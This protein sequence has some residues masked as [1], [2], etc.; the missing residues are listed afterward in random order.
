[1]KARRFLAVVLAVGLL[2]L[3]LGLGGWWWVLQRSPLRLQQQA[4][5]VP[6]TAR[7]MPR[8]V[9]LS[10]FLCS[11]GEQPVAY[12]RAVAPT[13]LRRQ[14]SDAVAALRDGAFAAAG[15]DYRT[16]LASWLGPEIGLGLIATDPG[17]PP[18]GW[19][20]ALRSR[21]ADGARRFLQRFWQTRSLAGA[22][23]QISSYRGM[24]LISGRGALPGADTAP[25]ATALIDEDLVLIASGRGVL[26]QA[27]DVSQLDELNL[28]ASPVVRQAV[29]RLGRGAALLTA[30]A[31]GLSGGLGL[32]D[33][34]DGE[35]RTLVA[36]LRPDGTSLELEGFLERSADV[37]PWR[38]R[39]DPQRGADLLS[40]LA[41]DAASLA[42]IENPAGWPELLQP[43]LS[44]VLAPSAGPLPPLLLAADAGPLLW[45]QSAAGW[46]VGTAAE[47]PPLELLDQALARQSLI[48]APLQLADQAAVRVWTSL[49]AA[50]RGSRRTSQ[51]PELQ[52]E[53]AGVRA[54]DGGLAWWAEN[55]AVLAEQ[56]TG[57]QPPRRRL[58]Q[59][60]E[61]GLPSAPLR[62]AAGSGRAGELLQ[63]WRPWRLLTALAAQPLTP[64]VQGLSL[65]LEPD[66]AN[67]HLKARLDLG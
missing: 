58:A 63:D 50:A 6:R 9:G 3:S 45:S 67:L 31:A 25:L 47:Q 32:P 59:F 57:H 64:S 39:L 24:G 48:G 23:L 30:R 38:D 35:L 62:W 4:L 17:R 18:D 27:L 19:L 41:A 20:L 15:L 22:D 21:D 11:D 28:A 33:M 54:V 51:T 66:G 2:L 55:L 36:S 46:L 61:L 13:R 8:Q 7:F 52:A 26:E 29:Q 37:L 49:S 16:E 56:R 5:E 44:G 60:E 53:L 42:L 10:L 1:M 34:P 14:A 12:A 65:A 43:L 40:G